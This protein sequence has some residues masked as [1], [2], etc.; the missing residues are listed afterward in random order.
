[1]SP[2]R[3]RSAPTHAHGCGHRAP[4][5]PRLAGWEDF[6]LW[7]KLAAT[8]AHGVHVP[9]VLAR[10]QRIPSS[11]TPEQWAL[12]RELFPELLA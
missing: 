10:R 4:A 11:E 1:M 3:N 12:M 7:C 6:H 8:G 9:Q 5:R 2:C